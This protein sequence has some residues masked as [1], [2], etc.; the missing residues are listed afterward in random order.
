[1][2]IIGLTNKESGCGFH[3]VILPLAFMYDIK[4]YVTN[5][6]T[7]DKTENWDLLLYNRICQYDINWKETKELLGCQVVMDIDDHWNLPV[8][9]INYNTYLD[10]GKRIEKNLTEAD[11]VTVTN[12]NLLNKVKNPSPNRKSISI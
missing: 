4:G 10:I 12:V 7:E 6:I 2:N 8:N 1:M 11:L 5:Y 9:H 3:R